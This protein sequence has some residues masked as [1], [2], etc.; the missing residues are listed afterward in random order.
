V[1]EVRWNRFVAPEQQGGDREVRR[2][3]KGKAKKARPWK[4]DASIWAPRRVWA[5]A[6]AFLDTD[7]SLR[8]ALRR[9]WGRAVEE[10]GLDRYIAKR[11]DDGAE[12]ADGDGVV[13]EVGE[14]YDVLASHGGGGLLYSLYDYYCAQGSLQVVMP[15]PPLLPSPLSSLLSFFL[16]SSL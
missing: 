5:D 6:R 2:Y 10:R 14:V 11:D 12:D 3:S 1:Q 16:S 13:D 8:K 7:D 15:L 4:L 9:D